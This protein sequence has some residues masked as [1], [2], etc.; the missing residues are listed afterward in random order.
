MFRIYPSIGI[1]VALL[2]EALG[3]KPGSTL[4]PFAL[5]ASSVSPNA[6]ERE[7][8][9]AGESFVKVLSARER[10][11]GVFAATRVNV[12]GDRLTAW[13]QQARNHGSQY[14]P[15]IKRFSQP[16]RI[17]DLSELVLDDKDLGDIRRCRPGDCGVKLG[18]VPR[19]EN[20]SVARV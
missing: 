4:E 14:V 12:G 11:I 6:T 15:I 7:K 9:D 2:T 19:R 18:G 3:A 13:A 5:F 20:P 8:L 17:E 1:V 10:D 16:P